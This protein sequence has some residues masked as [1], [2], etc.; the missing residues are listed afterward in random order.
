[1]WSERP[2]CRGTYTASPSLDALGSS[3]PR[4]PPKRPRAPSSGY[5]PL[6]VSSTSSHVLLLLLPASHPDTSRVPSPVPGACRARTKS[7][8]ARCH[9]PIPR[10]P[11]VQQH[12]IGQPIKHGGDRTAAPEPRA[13]D[14][15][16]F[17]TKYSM[18]D[19][20]LAS[21]PPPW[22]MPSCSPGMTQARGAARPAVACSKQGPRLSGS[23][24]PTPP[25]VGVA[26]TPA[27]FSP[28]RRLWH[29]RP[30]RRKL[31]TCRILIY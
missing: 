30:P 18:Y 13:W 8:R 29:A 23:P 7:S 9:Q 28:L 12:A 10:P 27:S 20:F 11:G 14:A 19:T 6:P 2:A 4:P 15:K 21:S 16:C 25:S 17:V 5:P 22:T 3:H 1:M 31:A 26:P 24:T